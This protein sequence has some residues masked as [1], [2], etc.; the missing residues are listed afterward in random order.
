MLMV[1][2]P[3]LGPDSVAVAFAANATS[4]VTIKVKN[5]FM[6]IK[7][8]IF[9]IYNYVGYVSFTVLLHLHAFGVQNYFLLFL[10]AKQL[11]GSFGEGNKAKLQ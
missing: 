3:S 8:L 10:C 2:M 1:M 7:L 11:K 5:F 4:A 6:L 9:V